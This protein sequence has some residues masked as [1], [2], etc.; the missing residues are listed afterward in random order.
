MNF[1][2][3]NEVSEE[4]PP[5]LIA[6]LPIDL[7]IVPTLSLLFERP[8]VRATVGKKKRTGSDSRVCFAV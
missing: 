1:L 3:P 6:F 2:P 4:V 8:T 5:F 7:G